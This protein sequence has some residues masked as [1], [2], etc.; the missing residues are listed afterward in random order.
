MPIV[1]LNRVLGLSDPRYNISV[2]G[3]FLGKM[4]PREI[5]KYRKAKEKETKA[6]KATWILRILATVGRPARSQYPE[7]IDEKVSKL[8]MGA[9]AADW[10]GKKLRGEIY[11]NIRKRLN[12]PENTRITVNSGLA[13]TK[14]KKMLLLQR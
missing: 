7:I 2:N 4:I 3:I 12:L 11:E 9:A 8:L 5:E 10:E 14:I 13:D 6:K 1:I